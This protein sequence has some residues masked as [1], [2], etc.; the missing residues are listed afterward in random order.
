VPVRQ[1]DKRYIG[2]EVAEEPSSERARDTIRKSDDPQAFEQGGHGA[3]PLSKKD[4]AA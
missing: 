4:R 2:A 3:D 1:F